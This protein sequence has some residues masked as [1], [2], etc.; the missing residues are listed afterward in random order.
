[1]REPWE[2]LTAGPQDAD[3]SVFLLPDEVPQHGRWSQRKWRTLN[4]CV[5]G[6]GGSG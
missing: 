2:I 5:D 4:A 1:M 3:R 6:S